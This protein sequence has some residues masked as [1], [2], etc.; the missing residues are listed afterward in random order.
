MLASSFIGLQ[1]F[2]GSAADLHEGE[3]SRNDIGANVQDSGFDVARLQDQVVFIDNGINFDGSALDIP[4][5]N[6]PSGP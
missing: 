1:L 5:P 3:V 2:D 6:L 4:Q